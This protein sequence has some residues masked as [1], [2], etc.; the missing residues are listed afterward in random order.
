MLPFE[1]FDPPPSPEVFGLPESLELRE[2]LEP[3]ES[4]EPPESLEPP[5]SAEPPESLEPDDASLDDEL[6]DSA[7]AAFVFEV[8]ELD[9]SFFAQPE[10]LKWTLGGTN[11]FRSVPS[12]PHV[13]QNRGPGASMPWM[14]SVRVEQFEQM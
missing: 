11:A 3:R 12:A 7:A 1:S 8:L 2:S 14:N 4:A 10:P 5:E 6:P 13:G 9:R